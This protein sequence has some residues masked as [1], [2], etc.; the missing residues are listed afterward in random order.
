[1]AKHGVHLPCIMFVNFLLTLP[2]SINLVPMS[3]RFLFQQKAKIGE[4]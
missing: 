3:V 1:M 4:F 2:L